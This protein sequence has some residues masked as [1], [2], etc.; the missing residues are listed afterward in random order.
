MDASVLVIMVV[1]VGVGDWEASL[2]GID[3]WDIK[4]VSSVQFNKAQQMV[5]GNGTEMW[6]LLVLKAIYSRLTSRL[7]GLP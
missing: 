5:K 6:E 3:D 2:L 4:K 7:I 1:S